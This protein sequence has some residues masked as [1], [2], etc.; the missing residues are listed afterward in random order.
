MENITLLFSILGF[1]LEENAS[2]IFAKKYTDSCVIEVDSEK[3][4]IKT[5]IKTN[6]FILL[7]GYI[8][9]RRQQPHQRI[10]G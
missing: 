4:S 7:Y 1:S 8:T 5:E 3:E 10:C 2:G 6:S 9:C